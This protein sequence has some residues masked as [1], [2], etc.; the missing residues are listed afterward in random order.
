MHEQSATVL[1]TRTIHT[2]TVFIT[3]S[4]RLRLPNGRETTMDVVRHRPSVVLI[5]MPD[6]AH[7]VLVRQYRYCIDSWI[8]ELPAG[9]VDPGEDIETAA[10]RECHEEIGQVPERVDRI[11]ELYPTPGYCDELMVF[12][13]F[14]GL[15][16]P[17]RQAHSDEDE[18]LEPRVFS[19]AE[20]RAL[21]EQ[22][23][24]QDM[25]TALGLTY[26]TVP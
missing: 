12:F 22:G 17:D 3:T 6:A 26:C 10:R 8:W 11:A 21:V 16:T 5:P 24:I 15:S 1:G 19:V 2:G 7:V 25:K 20:A 13:R 18:I 9:S 4:D 23:Q 14:R